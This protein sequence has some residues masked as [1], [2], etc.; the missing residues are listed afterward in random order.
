MTSFKKICVTP[1]K[2]IMAIVAFLISGF[3][4]ANVFSTSAISTVI[5]N[6]GAPEEV[7]G[8]WIPTEEDIAYQD[9]MWT[10]I[11]KTQS[12]VDTIKK[13]I[14]KIL[15]KL[16]KLEYE[17]GTWDSVRIKRTTNEKN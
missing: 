2:V 11:N 4:L 15:Y 17:D 3:I 9:S 12:D 16:D 5:E 6:E 7:E 8:M 13:D 10:I 1:R 14:D